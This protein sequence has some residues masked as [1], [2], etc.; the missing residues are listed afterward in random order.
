MAPKKKAL[1]MGLDGLIGGGT[2]TPASKKKTDET[3]TVANITTDTKEKTG[4]TMLNI[5]MIE[6]NRDQPRKNFN[7][8]ALIELSESIKKVGVICPILV[9][10]RDNYYEIVA[11]E[12]RWRASKLAGLKEMPVVIKD[13]DP[14]ETLVTALVENIQRESLN[15]I[16]EAKAYKTLIN[17]YK[18]KQDEV[19]EQVGKSRSVITNAMRLLKLDEK[20]QNLLIEDSISM[21]HARALIPIE[22]DEIRFRMA[23]VVM[24]G[25]LSARETEKMVKEILPLSKEE[26]NVIIG[27]IEKE[28]EE[29]IFTGLHIEKRLKALQKKADEKSSKNEKKDDF[30][31]IYEDIAEKI[32]SKIGTKVQIQNKAKGK[33]KIEIEYYSNDELDRIMQLIMSIK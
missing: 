20:V 4:P 21:G 23:T 27:E 7:E 10:K 6:P 14:Q 11:G 3:D 32:A 15:P 1:G 29:G 25:K 26:Q 16:E 8:D 2:K 31:F 28:L 18:L 24:D 9:Q 17:E 13:M 12:R 30:S 19:A 22:N 33:G 5:T